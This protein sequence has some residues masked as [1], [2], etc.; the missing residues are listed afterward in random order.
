[1]V[2]SQRDQH[3]FGDVLIA[4]ECLPAHQM[5]HVRGGNVALRDRYGR[6]ARG[7]WSGCRGPRIAHNEH[8]RMGFKLQ[9]LVD[10]RAAY[11]VMLHGQG[12]NERMRADARSPDNCFR[13]E[14]LA[15]LEF[16]TTSKATRCSRVR[17]HFDS[18]P[19]EALAGMRGKLRMDA[20]KYVRRGFKKDKANIFRADTTV[21]AR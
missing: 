11:A 6:D 5:G 17:A 16:H 18:L 10:E 15:I 8:F 2:H 14:S 12:L 9:M 21:M 1:V 19:I 13:C 4:F 7:V 3:A 20:A